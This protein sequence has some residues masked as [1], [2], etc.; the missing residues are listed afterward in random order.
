[1]QCGESFAERCC[2]AARS[3]FQVFEHQ[4]A[5]AACY[6]VR[7]GARDLDGTVAAIAA[8]PAA[9]ATNIR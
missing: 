5:L 6:A 2:V 9:S 4:I 3:Q 8:S 1:M 7:D